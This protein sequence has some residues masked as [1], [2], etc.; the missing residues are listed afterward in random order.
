[1]RRAILSLALLSLGAG[2]DHEDVAGRLTCAI[3]DEDVVCDVDG[4]TSVKFVQ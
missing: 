1:M 4:C 3:Y 2:C